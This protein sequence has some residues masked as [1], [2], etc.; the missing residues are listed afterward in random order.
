MS[1]VDSPRHSQAYKIVSC[2]MVLFVLYVVPHIMCHVFLRMQQ[3][4]P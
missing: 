3:A 4:R 2:F 1:F